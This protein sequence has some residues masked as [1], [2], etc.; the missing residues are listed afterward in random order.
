MICY[1][2]GK[3][4]IK[5]FREDASSSLYRLFFYSCCPK[6]FEIKGKLTKHMHVVVCI[7]LF[8][9]IMIVMIRK[10]YKNKI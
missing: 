10:M 6:I 3:K 5:E 8:C 4:I 9:M 1:I 7:E 2:T